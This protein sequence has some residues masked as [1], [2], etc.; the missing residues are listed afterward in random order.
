MC[1]TGLATRFIRARGVAES[2]IY[3]SVGTCT[4]PQ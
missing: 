1:T 2:I 3:A 4:R